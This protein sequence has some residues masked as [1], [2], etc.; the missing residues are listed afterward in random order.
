MVQRLKRSRTLRKRNQKGNGFF[1]RL[2][3]SPRRAVS[4]IKSTPGKM[5][6]LLNRKTP[7]SETP[8]A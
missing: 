6:N 2:M 8:E 3:G 1:S 4:A 7:K 5:M